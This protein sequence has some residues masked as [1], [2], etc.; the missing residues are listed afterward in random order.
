[1]RQNALKLLPAVM[2]SRDHLMVAHHHRAYRDF[3][4]RGRFP[5]L[6]QCQTHKAGI[7]EGAITTEI[8]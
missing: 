4:S 2:A 8:M 3:T 7:S 1:M 5:C 6:I